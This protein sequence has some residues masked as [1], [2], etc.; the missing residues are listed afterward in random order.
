MTR[1]LQGFAFLVQIRTFVIYL[2]GI[3]KFE[4]E[5]KNLQDSGCSSKIIPSRRAVKKFL[6]SRLILDN[7]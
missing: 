2:A 6:S 5:R 3:T 1:I 7:E 4:Y